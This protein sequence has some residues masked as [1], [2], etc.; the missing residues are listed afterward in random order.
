MRFTS[1]SLLRS[2][3][4]QTVRSPSTLLYAFWNIVLYS[5]EDKAFTAAAARSSRNSENAKPMR[6]GEP[7][8]G[9]RQDDEGEA[10]DDVGEVSVGEPLLAL[11]P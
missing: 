9:L 11:L 5:Q 4:P 2:A 6:G 8:A 7:A 10:T 1:S 3:K